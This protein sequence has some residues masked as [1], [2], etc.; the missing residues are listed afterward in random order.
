MLDQNNPT[1]SES[2]PQP[3]HNESVWN[4]VA[5]AGIKI[6]PHLA[7]PRGWLASVNGR[8]L[9]P[10]ATREEALGAMIRFLI[11][12]L[13]DAEN[14]QQKNA[15]KTSGWDWLEA[16]LAGANIFS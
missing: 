11:E 16:L 5:N 9:G 10:F 6:R 12:R 3:T 13:Q 15:S 8:Q 7:D 4:V 1:S 2:M 14:Q